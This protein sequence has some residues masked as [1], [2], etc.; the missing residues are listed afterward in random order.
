MEHYPAILALWHI[1]VRELLLISAVAIAISGTDDLFIDI[2]FFSRTLWRRLTVYTRHDRATA[3]SLR[4][5][6]PGA[7]AIIIP[8]WDESAVIGA[9]LASTLQRLDYPRYRIFVG[10]YPN[11][12]A[13]MAAVSLVRDPRIEIVQCSRPGPTTKADCLNHI[14]AA[15]LTHESRAG[16]P[17]KA[18]VLH[19]A[20]DVIHPQELWVFDALIPRLALVQLPVLPLPDR[21]SRWISGHYLDEFAENHTKDMAVREALGAAVPSAGVACAID[22]RYLGRIAAGRSS[23]RQARPGPFDAESLTEDYELGHRIKAM[24]GR[25]GL[26]RVRSN[27]ERVV[28]ATREHFPADLESALRQKSRWLTG[29]ALSGWD[30]LGWQG[31]IGSRYMML[32]DRKA[33]FTAPLAI[34]GYAVAVLVALDMLLRRDVSLAAAMP[35]L[36]GPGLAA[37]LWFN[38]ALLVWR[39]VLRAGFTGHSHGWAE[40]LRAIPRTLA[41]NIIN[42][43]AA[44]RAMLRY[45]AIVNGQ[46]RLGWDKT[47]HRFPDDLATIGAVAPPAV[48][49][50]APKPEPAVPVP[51]PALSALPV[52]AVP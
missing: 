19:D 12:P 34:I 46:A 27:N 35:P 1:A 24:G 36:I 37:L 28:V 20:E 48:I 32:R 17:F 18:I 7:I 8:A 30:R 29:I 2:V 16:S 47:D 50:V 25:G 11:D 6:D 51:P 15:I 31:G 40:G 10:V 22:R 26:V 38:A 41:S 52:A 33:L 14:W 42:A 4:R 13:G 5:R 21:S 45:H 39:L 43:A 3:E 44:W 49:G 23:S 9:M